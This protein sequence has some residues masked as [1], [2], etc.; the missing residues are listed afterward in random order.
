[1][2][3]VKTRETI[4]YEKGLKTLH[5]LSLKKALSEDGVDTSK[6]PRKILDT[7]GRLVDKQG[8]VR[9]KYQVIITKA[10]QE[11]SAIIT[12]AQQDSQAEQAEIQKGVEEI[13]KSIK[14][15]QGIITPIPEVPQTQP[16]AEPEKESVEEEVK[17]EHEAGEPGQA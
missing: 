3:K 1:M 12:K 4:E 14:I 5:E 15:E 10:Q 8:P 11:A 9:Q 2:N 6:V 7:I 17:K 16:E 13:I